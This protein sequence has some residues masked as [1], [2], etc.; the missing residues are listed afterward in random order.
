M[1]NM[2]QQYAENISRAKFGLAGCIREPRATVDRIA[3]GKRKQLH[4]QVPVKNRKVA[5]ILRILK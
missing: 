2:Y 3:I 1:Y 5:L 4:R